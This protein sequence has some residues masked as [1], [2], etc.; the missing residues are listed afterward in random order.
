MNLDLEKRVRFTDAAIEAAILK[1][2]NRPLNELSAS[3]V[4]TLVKG[5]LMEVLAELERPPEL[6]PIFYTRQQASVVLGISLR[7]LDY[8][9]KNH[10]IPTVQVGK[11]SMINSEVLRSLRQNGELIL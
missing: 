9:V 3:D 11:K 2:T 6:V 7:K 8:L 1:T 10:E 5:A 4:S